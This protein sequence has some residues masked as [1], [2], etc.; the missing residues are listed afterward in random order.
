[1]AFFFSQK[2]YFFYDEGLSSP[3]I[4]D[5]PLSFVRGCL[6]SIFAATFHP[7]PKDASCCGDRDP[8]N[9]VNTRTVKRLI[10]IIISF[11][12]K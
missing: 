12:E 2:V 1:M 10:A 9:M 8:P 4:G 5:H 11:Q 3:G 6:F 7:Q